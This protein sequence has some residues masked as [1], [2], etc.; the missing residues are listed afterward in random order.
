MVIISGGV[1]KPQCVICSKV[2][3]PDSMRPAKAKKP[4][5]I[6]EELIVPCCEVLV[7]HMIGDPQAKKL[8]EV[9]HSGHLGGNRIISL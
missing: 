7:K 8:R 2:L 6:A 5:T 3:T 1:E 9:Y 4:H